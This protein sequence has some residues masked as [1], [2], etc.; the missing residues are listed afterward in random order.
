MRYDYIHKE[1]GRPILLTYSKWY[2]LVFL[3]VIDYIP[4]LKKI[5]LAISFNNKETGIF[6]AHY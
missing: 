4:V 3:S 5:R 6:I 1:K 2:Q